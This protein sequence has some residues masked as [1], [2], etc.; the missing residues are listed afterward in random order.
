MNGWLLGLV[1]IVVLPLLALLV[2]DAIAVAI[3]EPRAERAE[4]MARERAARSEMNA[5][6]LGVL[7]Q[8]L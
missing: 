5:E 4:R 6:E 2:V 3:S 1:L 8:A 7:L